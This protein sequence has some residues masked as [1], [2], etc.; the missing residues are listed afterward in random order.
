MASNDLPQRG[1]SHVLGELGVGAVK[2]CF[3]AEWICREESPDYGI[4]LVVE[5][6]KG[7]SVT[8]IRFGIQVKGK[9]LSQK[10]DSLRIGGIKASTINYWHHR[11]KR[12]MLP[13]YLA[14]KD[15]IVWRWGDDIA[16]PG[17]KENTITIP[18]D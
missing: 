18:Q 10:G 6:V 2:G 12:I 13:A 7:T 1:R 11:S 8:G 3:P 17:T 4:D 5:I 14:E 16:V 15:I 9:D